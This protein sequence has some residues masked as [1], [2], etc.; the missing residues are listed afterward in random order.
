MLPRNLCQIPK[1]IAQRP[2]MIEINKICES[3]F[4]VNCLY[5]HIE[6]SFDN[7]A[8]YILPEGWR[9]SAQGPKMIQKRG[10]FSKKIPSNW[11]SGYVESIFGT[12]A[13]KFLLED[14]KFFAQSSKM[15]QK[16]DIKKMSRRIL[17]DT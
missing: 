16:V 7:S 1:L 11:P 13:H 14:K 8:K 2:K 10:F 9:V 15:F 12:T 17:P 3:C 6:K 4:S 5:G